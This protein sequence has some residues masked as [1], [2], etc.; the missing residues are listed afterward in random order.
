MSLFHCRS[1]QSLE[2][3]WNERLFCELYQAYLAGR[4]DKDPASFWYP[5]EL[6][7]FDN[8]IIPLTKKLK[9]C[10]VFGVTSDEYLS[11]ALANREEWE[12]K[13]KDIVASMVEKCKKGTIAEEKEDDDEEAGISC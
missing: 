8:Y 12:Q 6:G 2:Q 9:E 3:K 7:F 5:G 11:Y 10:N 1:I 4:M 13:G